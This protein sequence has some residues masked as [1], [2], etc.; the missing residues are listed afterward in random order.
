MAR[1]RFRLSYIDDI[2]FN[3]GVVYITDAGS[4]GLMVLELATGRV[5]RVLD[6]HPS[7][8]DQRTMYADGEV[9]RNANGDEVRMHADHLEVSPDGRYLYYQPASGPLSRIETRW[10]DDPSVPADTLADHIEA[11]VDTPTTGGTAIDANGVIYLSDVNRRRILTI[12]PDRQVETLIADPRLIWSDAM[13]IDGEGYL[14]IPATQLNRALA[15]GRLGV[16]YPVWIY[17]MHVG[18]CPPAIDHP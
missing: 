9:L 18:V 13:W 3:N 8:S 2:R 14:W 4:P 17:K 12:T 11:W 16:D 1:I 15:G 6:N 5:R 7:T 10:L